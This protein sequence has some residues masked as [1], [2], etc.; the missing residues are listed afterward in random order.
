MFVI[1][2]LLLGAVGGGLRARARGGKRADIAQYAAVYGILFGLI[3]LFLTIYLD[4][5]LRG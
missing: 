4:R 3:G 5:M 1:G 2:G